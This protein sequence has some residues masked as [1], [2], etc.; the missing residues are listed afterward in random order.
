MTLLFNCNSR[1]CVK[2][3]LLA[4]I[5]GLPIC[6][7]CTLAEMLFSL[8][9]CYYY[10]YYIISVI[11]GPHQSISHIYFSVFWVSHLDLCHLCLN[12]GKVTSI[13]MSTPAS[14]S[15][16][17][18]FLDCLT[19]SISYSK[20][21]PSPWFT[22]KLQTIRRNG[23]SVHLEANKD[24]VISHKAVLGQTRSNINPLSL[25]TS[26]INP[27]N[28]LLPYICCSAILTPP[29]WCLYILL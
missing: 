13:S 20:P 3:N 22:A 16:L 7:I 8:S 2:W 9:I 10:Y 29:S 18:T 19:A 5:A 17:L 21:S 24:H 25:K 14:A 27:N 26:N 15:L 11:Y 28:Y 1:G 4:N 6:W 12:Y 23:V